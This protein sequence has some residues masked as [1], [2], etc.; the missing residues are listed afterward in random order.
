MITWPQKVT[1]MS[2]SL[3]MTCSEA[4]R[5]SMME[6]RDS[7]PAARDAALKDLYA[8]LTKEQQALADHRL[9]SRPGHRTAWRASAK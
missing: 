6:V 8:V 5:E 4:L 1:V 7:H 9:M 3:W 2:R